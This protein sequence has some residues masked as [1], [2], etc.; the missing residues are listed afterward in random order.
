MS[1][2]S[3]IAGAVG[4]IIGGIQ[5]R[6]AA[7]NAGQAEETYA[8]KAL[9]LE[10][11]DQQQGINF[12]NNLW[13]TDTGNLN[14]YI[15]GGQGAE[16]TL[17]DLTSTP[18][19]GLLQQYQPFTAPTLAQAE[20]MPGYQFESQQMQQ[21]VQNAAA[22]KGELLDPNAAQAEIQTAQ[23][24][25]QSNYGQAY[26]EAQQT[27]GTNY[28]AFEQQQQNEYNR[29]LGVAGLGESAA[30]TEG[31][32][33]GQIGNTMANL[34]LTGGAQQAQQENNIGSAIA[35]T[36]IGSA[37]AWNS[38]ISGIL[39]SAPGASGSAYQSPFGNGNP[40]GG[41][42]GSSFSFAGFNGQDMSGMNNPT[43]SAG[44]DGAIPAV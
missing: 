42:G 18:G 13:G 12:E 22:A 2:I 39:A 9:A 28:T 17:S 26:N 24:L 23:N 44:A 43:P 7:Q 15:T 4:S 38:M 25:A 41:G 14:P 40:F 35:G 21:A 30:G 1:W 36:D 11:Q 16:L 20:E 8:E 34:L 10:Q 5:S 6:N 3:N 19:Q 32:L 27:Y 31:A 33:G 29:L 37:N